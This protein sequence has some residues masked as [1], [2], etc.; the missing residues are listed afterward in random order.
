MFPEASLF[1]SAGFRTGRER[2]EGGSNDFDMKIFS[3]IPATVFFR[4]AARKPSG[5]T[6]YR[7]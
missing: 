4:I 7:N 1:N 3:P 5:V 6:G 2:C